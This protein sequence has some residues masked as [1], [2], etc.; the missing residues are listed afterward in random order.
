MAL[1]YTR[2]TAG[3]TERR[4]EKCEQ[5]SFPI[6]LAGFGWCAAYCPTWGD[7]CGAGRA[8]K[9]LSDSNLLSGDRSLILMLRKEWH[10]CGGKVLTRG[11]KA[12][13]SNPPLL[14]QSF[15][16]SV[17]ERIFVFLPSRFCTS[18]FEEFSAVLCRPCFAVSRSCPLGFLRRG[19]SC[20]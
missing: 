6:S 4:A 12:P 18:P 15:L 2:E 5:Q 11:A 16:S 17:G 19:H 7:V 13:R 9:L 14:S 20:L 8:V 10:A 3:R 1:C